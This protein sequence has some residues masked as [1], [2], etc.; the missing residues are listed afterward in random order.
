MLTGR[1]LELACRALNHF[2]HRCKRC[3]AY[4]MALSES[5]ATCAACK[6]PRWNTERTGNPPGVKPKGRPAE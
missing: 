2:Y 1:A 3:G 5:P 4:F 6:N